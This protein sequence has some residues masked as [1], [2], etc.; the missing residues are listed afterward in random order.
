MIKLGI[1]D[2]TA[3][4]AVENRSHPRWAKLVEL[5]DNDTEAELRY[6]GR[7]IAEVLKITGAK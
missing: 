1:M 3:K 5:T 6:Q 2:R 7:S 4:A